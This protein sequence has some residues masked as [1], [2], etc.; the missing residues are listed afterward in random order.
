M[1]SF[2]KA[3]ANER[4][5]ACASYS[6]SL[7]VG[8]K[9]NLKVYSILLPSGDHNRIPAP[10]PPG[11]LAKSMYRKPDL[12]VSGLDHVD[13]L[14]CLLLRP[15]DALD[16]EVCQRICLDVRSQLVPEFKLARLC[17]P[18]NDLSG[19]VWVLQDLPSRLVCDYFHRMHLKVRLELGYLV[20]APRMTRL[21]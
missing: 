11:L 9:F 10:E 2:P 12:F 8:M 7:F 20:S 4:P 15:M 14:G 21:T 5:L 17:S 13:K 6:T 16:H 18:F 3:F 1:S 19:S